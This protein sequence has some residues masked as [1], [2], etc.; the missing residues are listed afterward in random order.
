MSGCVSSCSERCMFTGISEGLIVCCWVAWGMSGCVSSCCERCMF[1][2]ISEGLIVCCWVAW[3]MSGRVSS[4]SE[5]SNVASPWGLVIFGWAFM[6][7]LVDGE[8]SHPRLL[9]R[10]M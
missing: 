2:G 8:T 10:A 7:S 4:C 1:T 9:A 6:A 5:H 3:G